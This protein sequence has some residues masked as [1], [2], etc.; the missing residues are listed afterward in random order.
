VVGL[1]D[2]QADLR[3][4]REQLPEDRLVRGRARQVR[5][6]RLVGCGARGGV[7][8]RAQ[9]TGGE[10]GSGPMMSKRQPCG[11]P[12]SFVSCDRPVALGEVGDVRTPKPNCS[13][14]TSLKNV[15]P[16]FWIS[17]P[18]RHSSGASFVPFGFQ[19]PPS[20]VGLQLSDPRV[21]FVSR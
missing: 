20:S 11:Q 12:G 19:P 2:G 10:A 5:R 8:N 16:T 17:A 4:P 13:P 14:H 15:P 21:A 7:G 6:L 3:L 18:L 1:E 9:A